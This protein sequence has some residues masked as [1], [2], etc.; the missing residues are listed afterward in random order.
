MPNFKSN[1]W[2][3]HFI[4]AVII[5]FLWDQVVL[6]D[7]EFIHRA[8]Y[9]SSI[10]YRTRDDI[11]GLAPWTELK[12]K[13]VYFE[14][15]PETERQKTE[16]TKRGQNSPGYLSVEFSPISIKNILKFALPMFLLVML[17]HAIE[18]YL[19]TH[20]EQLI[21]LVDKEALIPVAESYFEAMQ[22]KYNF[23]E[24]IKII[25]DVSGFKGR[26]FLRLI[27]FRGALHHLLAMP[28][29][30]CLIVGLVFIEKFIQKII[31]MSR[32]HSVFKEKTHQFIEISY[33]TA[34]F[35][36]MFGLALQTLDH[37]KYHG[38][39]FNYL[40]HYSPGDVLMMFG[41]L[42]LGTLIF[43]LVVTYDMLRATERVR[44]E[45]PFSERGSISV[46]PKERVPQNYLPP[47]REDRRISCFI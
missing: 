45:P 13:P 16:D 21:V 5:T 10:A 38:G 3:K 29:I 20:T 23:P 43:G 41:I 35:S 15:H 22:N 40:S 34:L 39:V 14:P 37:I 17:N 25:S 28:L 46:I 18:E 44:N 11:H 42:L 8:Q 36:V 30:S 9:R 33:L 27:H 31:H 26:F 47:Q 32:A 12:E 6:S 24:G 1:I 4:W 7:P 2:F 19:L